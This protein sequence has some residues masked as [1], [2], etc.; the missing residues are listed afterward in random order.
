MSSDFSLSHQEY[1]K[2]C[3]GNEVRAQLNQILIAVQIVVS[4]FLTWLLKLREN[5]NHK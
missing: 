3:L 1:G 5:A 2:R 4:D